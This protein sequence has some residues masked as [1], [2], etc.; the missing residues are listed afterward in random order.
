MVELVAAY[1]QTTENL[2]KNANKY[3]YNGIHAYPVGK[4]AFVTDDNTTS[5]TTNSTPATTSK[6]KTK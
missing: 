1:T 2:I 3:D 5:I 6:T 4:N